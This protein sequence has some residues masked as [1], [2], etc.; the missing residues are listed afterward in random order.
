MRAVRFGVL[1][2]YCRNEFVYT[3][4]TRHDVEHPGQLLQKV[5]AECDSTFHPREK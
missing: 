4:L 1:F 2:V 5:V 3:Q